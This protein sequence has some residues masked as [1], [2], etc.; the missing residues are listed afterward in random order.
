MAEFRSRDPVDR[1]I[2]R[3]LETVLIIKKCKLTIQKSKDLTDEADFSKAERDSVNRS[4][5]DNER[6]LPSI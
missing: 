6:D 5:T 2:R 1:A 3:V 4:K